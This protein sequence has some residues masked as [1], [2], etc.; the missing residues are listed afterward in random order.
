MRRG[1]GGRSGVA[2]D[3]GDGGQAEIVSA[4]WPGATLAPVRLHRGRERPGLELLALPGP[5][6]PTVLV[7]LRPWRATA[8]VL[9]AHRSP[10]SARQRLEHL[11]L[12]TFGRLG[13]AGLV[14]R[15]VSVRQHA[16]SPQPSIETYLRS[17]MGEPVVIGIHLGPPRANRKPIVQAMSTTGRTLAFAKVGVN[18]LTR[19]LVRGE[20]TTLAALAKVTLTQLEIPSVLHAGRWGDSELLVLSPVPTTSRTAAGAGVLQRAMVELCRVYEQQRRPLSASDY[21]QG[22]RSRV[23]KL[24]GAQADDL[25]SAVRRLASTCGQVDVELGAWHGDWTPWNMSARRDRVVVWDWERFRAGVPAGFDALHYTLQSDI[26]RGGTAPREAL[27]GLAAQSDELL[28]P[29]GVRRGGA[30]LV[31]ALYLIEIGSR[32][33]EDDQQR[34]GSR[35]GD[36]SSWLLPELDMIVDQAAED[37]RS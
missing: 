6:R 19:E 26:R 32:Y 28:E 11:A 3:E 20:G 13:G 14:P 33:L 30:A 29:F 15:R 4:L 7:P 8:A 9:G 1:R 5:S 27:R 24:S 10:A 17:V 34:A 2:P 16:E 23:E 37:A 12:V 22:V 21:W 31:T 25:S 35:L 18:S 36:L